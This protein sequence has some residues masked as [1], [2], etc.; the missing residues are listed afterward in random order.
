MKGLTP[1][2]IRALLHAS[3]NRTRLKVLTIQQPW[4]WA[5][6]AG[7]KDIENRTWATDY[8]GPLAIHS[9]KTWDRDG[10]QSCRS[11]LEDKGVVKEGEQVGERHLLATG[12]VLA[13]VE[14]VDICPGRLCRC[15]AWA[16]IG[17]KHWKLRDARPLA[18][19]VPATGRLGLW[20]IDLQG[21][22]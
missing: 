12:A 3:R 1:E 11:V 14:L 2:Q 13:V 21:V 5:I 16:A 20:D 6:A 17:C 18:E 22:A 15:N 8:R 19:P 10:M 4:A 9:S 7:H